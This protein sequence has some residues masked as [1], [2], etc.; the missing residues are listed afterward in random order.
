M[1]PLFRNLQVALAVTQ[2]VGVPRDDDL[3]DIRGI[4]QLAGNCA[5]LMLAFVFQALEIGAAEGEQGVG[6]QRDGLDRTQ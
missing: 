3:A 5:Q 1:R 4:Q 6:F 2:L